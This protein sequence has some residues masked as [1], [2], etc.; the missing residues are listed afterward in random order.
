M[1]THHLLN[2]SSSPHWISASS[3]LYIKFPC[4]C[5]CS[6]ALC[7]HFILWSFPL[8]VPHGL[9]YYI[10]IMSLVQL[11]LFLAYSFLSFL[12]FFLS[13]FPSFLPSFFLFFSFFFFLRWVFIAVCRLSLVAASGGC[14][15]LRCAGFSLRWLLCLWSMGSRHAGFSS[16]GTWAQ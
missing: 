14:S 2:S 4:M 9:H 8:A 6:W 7:F 12:S 5:D 15:L 16:C 11:Q 13:F 3:W 1:S 10:C